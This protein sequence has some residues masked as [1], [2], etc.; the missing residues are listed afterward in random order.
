MDSQIPLVV[1]LCCLLGVLANSVWIWYRLRCTVNHVTG[2]YAKWTLEEPNNDT[3][4]DS[5]SFVND[6]S[7]EHLPKRHSFRDCDV[8][9]GN[10][11]SIASLKELIRKDIM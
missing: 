5:Q 11:A 4:G 6:G 1:S 7:H 8:L 2:F 9:E 3:H 10:Y